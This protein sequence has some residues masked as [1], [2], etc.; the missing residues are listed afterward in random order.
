[1]AI[2]TLCARSL[3]NRTSTISTPFSNRST[4]LGAEVSVQSAPATCARAQRKNSKLKIILAVSTEF[5]PVLINW[6]S[7]Y[8]ALCGSD[9]L[10]DLFFLCMDKGPND[11]LKLM[12]G[13][14]CDAIISTGV[15]NSPLVSQGAES[16]ARGVQSKIWFHRAEIAAQLLSGGYDVLLADLDAYWLRCPFPAIDALLAKGF[17]I[18]GS[19]G[20][21]PDDVAERFNSTLC[22]G[23]AYFCASAGTVQIFSAAVEAMRAQVR[24]DD[25]VSINR[26]VFLDGRMVALGPNPNP[27]PNL[28]LDGRPVAL[29]PTADAFQGAF[30]MGARD[31]RL[32]LLP[33]DVVTRSCNNKT[34]SAAHIAHCYSGDNLKRY[35]VK[36][37]AARTIGMWKVRR[38]WEN[39]LRRSHLV[40]NGTGSYIPSRLMQALTGPDY[41]FIK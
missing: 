6:A 38:D 27:D 20:T 25:Q 8:L 17:D 5:F 18:V 32:A 41:S 12:L 26:L 10:G 33:T 15:Y 24:P 16:A 40:N 7:Y 19:R 35:K 36:Y 14:Q 1:M 31:L 23:F 11:E 2:R 39:V 30:R 9:H 3:L 29:G 34:W 4:I 21:F 28:F 22:L 37:Q 13:M